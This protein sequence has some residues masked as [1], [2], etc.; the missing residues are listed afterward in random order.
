M[1]H[2]FCW[3]LGF[4]WAGGGGGEEHDPN[5]ISMDLFCEMQVCQV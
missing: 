3:F 2:G 4:V 1:N 5:S